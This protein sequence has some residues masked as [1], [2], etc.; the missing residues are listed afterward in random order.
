MTVTYL[1][2]PPSDQPLPPRVAYAI[3]RKVGGAVVRNRV[4]RRL[5]AIFAELA[6]P[7]QALVP[8]GAYLVSTGPAVGE[9][10]A[11]ELKEI[12]EAALHRIELPAPRRQGSLDA[13]QDDR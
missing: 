6:G 11:R 1:L 3:G 2:D 5:R 9:L 4:R 8:A 12:V 10:Q 13:R 7:S